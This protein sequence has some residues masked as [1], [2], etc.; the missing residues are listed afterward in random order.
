MSSRQ[1]L[2]ACADRCWG[3]PR[4]RLPSRELHR[5]EKWPTEGAGPG[6]VASLQSQVTGTWDTRVP[7]RSPEG[8]LHT[9]KT[10]SSRCSWRSP[11]HSSAVP[12]HPASRT[13]DATPRTTTQSGLGQGTSCPRSQLRRRRTEPGAG[14]WL[15]KGRLPSGGGT[16]ASLLAVHPL[17]SRDRDMVPRAPV[18]TP[19]PR[20]S[21]PP[22]LSCGGPSRAAA[23]GCAG[24]WA[25][26]LAGSGCSTGRWS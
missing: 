25:G 9:H 19:A 11:T 7:S 8:S 5:P 3:C 17:P 26:P 20:P 1:T 13:S 6:V 18:P 21:T 2:D 14:P 16:T 4:T 10:V 22:Q 15:R 23:V 12:L 24:L